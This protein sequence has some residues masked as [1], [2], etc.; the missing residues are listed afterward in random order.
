MSDML[1][2]AIRKAGYKRT[3]AI[4]AMALGT[5][6]QYSRDNAELSPG[7]KQYGAYNN[8]TIM[9]LSS[10][11]NLRVNLDFSPT[12][13]IIV[14]ASTTIALDEIVFQEFDIHNLSATDGLVA[15]ECWV[16]ISY[17]P[18]FKRDREIPI[19]GR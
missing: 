2:A 4:P 17:E 18:P 12:K 16:T 15:N 10:L 9:N 1:R 19:G 5:Q 8:I 14:P 3:I 11:V 7:L 6:L 13:Y